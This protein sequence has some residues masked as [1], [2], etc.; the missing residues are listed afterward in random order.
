MVRE[1]CSTHAHQEAHDKAALFAR[2]VN[3]AASTRALVGGRG[4][5]HAV[6]S[7][8]GLQDPT[9]IVDDP[10]LSGIHAA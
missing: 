10:L 7:G 5:A 8:V 2:R 9:W 6:A 1:H 4:D 3:A